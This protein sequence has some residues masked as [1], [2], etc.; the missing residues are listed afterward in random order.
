MELCLKNLEERKEQEAGN[1]RNIV[2][3]ENDVKVKCGFLLHWMV[4]FQGETFCFLCSYSKTQTP[5]ASQE[6][7]VSPVSITIYY[8]S[9]GRE[10][11]E[12]PKT[13]SSFLD[14][15]NTSGRSRLIF[16]CRG[17]GGSPSC[18]CYSGFTDVSCIALNC[19]IELSGF[20]LE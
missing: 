16:L 10:E 15:L 12:S 20:R 7:S 5:T 9:K 2:Q 4:I 11:G 1:R 13:W 8:T 19:F 17:I 18:L 14:Q 3:A 6:K